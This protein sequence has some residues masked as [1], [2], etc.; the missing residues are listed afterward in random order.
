VEAVT[1][2][3][4]SEPDNEFWEWSDRTIIDLLQNKVLG[5]QCYDY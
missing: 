2:V 1:E 5:G 3:N 4:S